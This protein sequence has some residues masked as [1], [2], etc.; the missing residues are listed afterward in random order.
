MCVTLLCTRLEAKQAS[1]FLL[2]SISR[3]TFGSVTTANNNNN[4]NNVRCR[5]E[6]ASSAAAAATSPSPGE[7][8]NPGASGGSESA[9][10]AGTAATPSYRR[11]YD[12]AM[13][14]LENELLLEPY[15]IPAGLEGN[16]AVV[17]KGRN[18][19]VPLL[20]RSATAGCCWACGRRIA[21]GVPVA[22]N[23]SHLKRRRCKLEAVDFDEQCIL[24]SYRGWIFPRLVFGIPSFTPSD[25][26]LASA[27][28]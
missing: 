27:R 6:K 19:Q 1:A 11:L 15:P 26:C 10:T 5:P 4:N 21:A 18:Q 8:R 28:S 17:G 24:C 13:Q 14:L 12:E 23:Q 25:A 2:S 3:Q 9:P 22:V 7:A 16:S 20:C